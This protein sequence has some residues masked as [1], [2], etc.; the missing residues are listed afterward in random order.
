MANDVLVSD[1]NTDL[2][3]HPV[4]KE[5]EGFGSETEVRSLIRYELNRALNPYTPE[6]RTIMTLQAERDEWKYMTYAACGLLLFIFFMAR[7]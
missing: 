4:T 1:R 2:D 5:S 3:A 6:E 7:R